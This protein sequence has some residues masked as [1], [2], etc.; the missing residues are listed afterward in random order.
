M[1]VE[2][3]N[4]SLSPRMAK[5]IRNKVRAGSYTNI[6]EVV[7]TA[8][9]RMQE[10]EARE[11]RSARPAAG[12]IL[13]KLSAEEV[14]LVTGRVREGFAA[15]GRGEYTDYIGREGLDRLGAEV[16]VRGRKRLVRTASSQ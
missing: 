14:A 4:I 6:S 15:I 10:E 8:V 2:Q 7:R 16:K 1:P 5:F 13:A 12:D 3:M 9:R 11:A